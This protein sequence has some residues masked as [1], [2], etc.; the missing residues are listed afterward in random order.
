MTEPISL[1]QAKRYLRLEDDDPGIDDLPVL[2]RA[3]RQTVEEFLNSTIV[4]RDRI[5]ILDCFPPWAIPLPNGP[6]K[7]I[8]KIDYIDND[9]VSQEIP[10]GQWILSQDVL[11]LPM[12][13]N[14][15]R[16]ALRSARLTSPIRPA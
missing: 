5:L 16:R 8:G 1:S 14:G 9:G 3:A 15:R 11:T 4:V 7:S 10:Q 13:N 12:V 6:V 2:I